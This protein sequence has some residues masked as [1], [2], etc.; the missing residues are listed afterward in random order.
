MLLNKNIVVDTANDNK[1]VTAYYN[2]SMQYK[3]RTFRFLTINAEIIHG[4]LLAFNNCRYCY[5]S[6]Y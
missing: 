5:L 3:Y 1:N 4:E 2:K 6:K